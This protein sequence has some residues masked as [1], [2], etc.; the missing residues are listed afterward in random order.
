[1]KIIQRIKCYFGFHKELY[2]VRHL[3]GKSDL[4]GCKDCK[5]Y[6]GMNHD[7]RAILP[8]TIDLCA[9]YRD[10]MGIKGLDKYITRPT[11]GGFL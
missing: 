7:V 5:R 1:M 4:I 2:I 6:Y 10:D 3:V 9:H 11:F 8:F